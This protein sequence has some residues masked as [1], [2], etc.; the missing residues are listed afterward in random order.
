MVGMNSP[1]APTT[2]RYLPLIQSVVAQA[3]FFVA[4]LY[5]LGY[6]VVT[7]FYGYF[8]LPARLL[9]DATSG[10]VLQGGRLLL[11]LAIIAFLIASAAV[12]AFQAVKRLHAHRPRAATAAVL[13]AVVLFVLLTGVTAPSGSLLPQ[14]LRATGTCGMLLCAMALVWLHANN[15][16]VPVLA[17]IG[18]RGRLLLVGV[19]GI[20]ILSVLGEICGFYSAR[21]AAGDP[22]TIPRVVIHS[23]DDLGLVGA[24]VTHL[25]GPGAD[26]KFKHEYRGLLALTRKNDR[27]YLVAAADPRAGVRIVPDSDSIQVDLQT[28]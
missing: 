6:F 28:R 15:P 22:G 23:E 27:W 26:T 9:G 1:S 18:R 3:A 19:L 17:L 21:L 2:D 14:V 16:H 11:W 7:S 10:I 13:A 20:A 8:G 24:G 25:A 12:P 4:A 5:F